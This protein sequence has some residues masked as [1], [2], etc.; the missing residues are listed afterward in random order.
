MRKQLSWLIL[1]FVFVVACFY[2]V[3]MQAH[4]KTNFETSCVEGS[5]GNSGR[6]LLVSAPDEGISLSKTN[7]TRILLFTCLNV[8]FEPASQKKS[9]QYDEPVSNS[10]ENG[11]ND[12]YNPCAC[13]NNDTGKIIDT[14]Y[15]PGSDLLSLVAC[16]NMTVM[17]INMMTSS[18]IEN[19]ID[20]IHYHLIL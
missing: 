5:T 19:M 14:H 12:V 17:A 6:I 10:I 2:S 1:L 15:L 7:M 11:S 13:L 8:S 3:P 4:I 9:Y 16:D 20:T 18:T